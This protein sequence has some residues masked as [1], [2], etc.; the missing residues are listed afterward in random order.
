MP[1]WKSSISLTKINLPPNQLI[2]FELFTLHRLALSCL[3]CTQYMKKHSRASLRV[4]G[5]GGEAINPKAWL[6]Y[7][8]VV[9]EGRCPI[10]D[11]WWQTETGA[12]MISP[13]P[14]AWPLKPG[15]ATLPFFGVQVKNHSIV[16]IQ[17]HLT[18]YTLTCLITQLA[19]WT[20]ILGYAFIACDMITKRDHQE[21][22]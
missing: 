19:L 8:G 10:V 7:H 16:Y 17:A 20:C 3:H 15:S 2:M 4:L 6:W 22:H 11:T 12:N 9:G 5:F 13:L 14:G 21:G 18:I 1:E